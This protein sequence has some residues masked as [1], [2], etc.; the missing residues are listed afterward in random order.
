MEE[1]EKF[2]NRIKQDGFEPN[3]V[4][5]GTLIK[6]YAKGNDT[7]KM[8]AKY[9][10]I[11]LCGIKANETIFTT[12]VDAH[13]RNHGFDSAVIWFN[14]MGSNSVLPDQK[15][16]NILLSL[17]KSA[18]EKAEANHLVG[19]ANENNDNRIL[20]NDDDGVND[21]ID[22]DFSD[23]SEETIQFTSKMN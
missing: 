8:M 7:G 4:T 1:P 21:N 9:E 18:E 12:I 20:S 3:V 16:K 6:G 13:V 17:A 23:D 14:E 5:N 10:E 22:E 11:R 19:Y 2:F 15:A